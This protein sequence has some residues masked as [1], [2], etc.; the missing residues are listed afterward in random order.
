MH[1]VITL[2]VLKCYVMCKKKI[3]RNV[4]IMTTNLLKVEK[5]LGF[6]NCPVQVQTKGQR[7]GFIFRY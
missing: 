4:L 3:R 1:Q 5:G 6:L 7:R 2:L